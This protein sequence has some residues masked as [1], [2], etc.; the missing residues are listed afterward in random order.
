MIKNIKIRVL[1]EVWANPQRLEEEVCRLNGISPKSLRGLRTLHRSI[2]ARQRQVMI[3]LDLD[4]YINEE[5]PQQLFQPLQYREVKGDKHAIVVGLGP[6]GLFAALKLI[7]LGIKPIVLERGRNVTDRRRDVAQITRTQQVDPESNF[8]FGEGGAGAFSDG[9][10]FTRSKKRGNAQAILERLCQFGAD[11]GIL[12]AAHPHIGTDRLPGV[13]ANIREEILRC[14]GEIHF[15]TCMTEL[16]LQG[17]KV[18]GVRTNRGEE[19]LGPVILATGHSA[20]DVYRM[21]FRKEIPIETKGIAMGVRLEHPQQL[22]DQIQYHSRE[23]RGK[24]LPAAEYSFVTQSQGRGVYSFCMC[25]GGVVVPS[26]TGPEQ[27]VVNGMSAS[28]RG[29]RWANSAMV[30]EIRTEDVA[31]MLS[32]CLDAELPTCRFLDEM[33]VADVKNSALAVMAL[34]ESI[35][36]MAWLNGTRSQVAPAQRM[37]DFIQGKCS[38]QLAES[39]Y[40]PGV[41]ASPLHFWMPKF[42]SSRLREG[43]STFGKNAHGFATNQATLIAAETR[44]SSP[45]RIPRDRELLHHPTIAGLYPCGEGAGFAGGIVSAAMDGERCAEALVQQCFAG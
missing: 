36:K 44:T 18:C 42:I 25:P 20:R 31:A 6:G 15:E 30:V 11:T 17:D 10:L 29:S 41:V 13:I 27:V 9:K 35:E 8:C 3:Q 39:S 43:L 2:D 26:A 34:Q 14:G 24:W 4:V 32:E 1:P 38:D 12:D 37:M 28:A 45:V 33:G 5:P 19:F 16:V 40:T 22:I 7:E 23:G 21:L